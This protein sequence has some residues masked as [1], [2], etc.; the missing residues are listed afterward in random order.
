MLRSTLQKQD[1]I[2]ATRFHCKNKRKREKIDKL[3]VRLVMQGQHMKLKDNTGQV[4]FTDAFSP[5][6]HSSG[7]RLLLGIATENDCSPTILTSPNHLRK[8]TFSLGHIFATCISPCQ[9][10]TQRTIFWV[11]R[12]TTIV[13]LRANI[14]RNVEY[15]GS[16]G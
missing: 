5:V 14:L 11:H 15:F 12:V 4:D 16:L 13:Y 6:P 1:K 8:G 10:S 9:Y 3:K 7:L 2:F